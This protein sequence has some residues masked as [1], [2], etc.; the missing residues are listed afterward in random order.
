[1]FPRVDTDTVKDMGMADWVSTMT[2]T[3]LSLS[4]GTLSIAHC[5]RISIKH[6]ISPKRGIILSHD[7]LT[8]YKE[9]S[10]FVAYSTTECTIVPLLQNLEENLR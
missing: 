10:I 8:P 2:T 7:R 9:M 1:M 6:V 4:I 5:P 3:F